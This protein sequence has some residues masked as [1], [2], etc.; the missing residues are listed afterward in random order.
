VFWSPPG[1]AVVR[2]VEQ[3]AVRWNAVVMNR[4]LN[5]DVN[6]ERWLASLLPSDAVVLDVGFN[7]GDFSDMVIQGRPE[8][9]CIGFDPARSMRLHY[10]TSYAHKGQ[11]ELMS[12][13]VSNAQGECLFQDLANGV[14]HVIVDTGNSGGGGNDS[15]R[16]PQITL[17][18]FVE[19]RGLEFIDFMKV[20]AEGYDLHVLEGSARLLARERIGMLMFEYNAPWIM[21]RRFLQEAVAFL[22]DKPYSLFRLFNGFLAPFGYTHKAERH[23]LGCNYVAV[24]KTYL[25]S[26]PV[27]IRTFP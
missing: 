13:A 10:E 4:S 25:A 27:P 16:V 19:E 26:R 14:S 23:D 3:V 11:V 9:R 1:R 21:T 7:R 20:D 17:D 6:G 24:S 22:E 8:A 15:Y 5:M 2:L 12:V 18:S